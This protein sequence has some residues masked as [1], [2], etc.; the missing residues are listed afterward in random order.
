[1]NITDKITGQKYEGILPFSF[2]VLSTNSA[3]RPALSTIK[4]INNGSID[5]PIV[6]QAS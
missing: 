3:L 2:T 5:I 1:M 4:L 6:G